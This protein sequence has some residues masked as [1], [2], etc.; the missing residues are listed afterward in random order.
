MYSK[1]ESKKLREDF[2]ISFRKSFPR[3]WIL[4][5]TKIKD[6]SF[7]FF[8]DRKKA[9][10]ALDIEDDAIENR[11]KYFDKLLALKTIFL[12]DYV[13]DAI[14]ESIYLLDNQ[15]E[16]SRIYVLKTDV[17]I[18][19]KDTWQDVMVFLYENMMQ[20]EKFWFEYEDF[21]KE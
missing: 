21:I 16:I 2:W 14:F 8:F 7:K 19:N 18:H 12:A 9:L 3:K 17:D 11:I 4:Y 10:V 5:N 15:K 1:A 13:A 20:F 6:F